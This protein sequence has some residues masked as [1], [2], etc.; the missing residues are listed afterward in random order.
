[1]LQRKSEFGPLLPLTKCVELIQGRGISEYDVCRAV[2]S[3]ECFGSGGVRIVYIAG[4]AYISSLP[5]ELSGDTSFILQA[6]T[7]G[8]EGLSVEELSERCRWPVERVLN[9]LYGL[10]IEGV[11]WEDRQTTPTLYWVPSLWLNS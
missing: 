2:N 11:V 10:T 5:E 7:R 8:S 4:G 9:A 3:L 1:M 6:F